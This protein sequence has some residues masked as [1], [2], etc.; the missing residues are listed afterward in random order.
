[1]KPAPD[2]IA[3]EVLARERQVWVALATGDAVADLAL[4]DEDFLGLYPD[5]PSGRSD[6]A[7]QLAAGPVAADWQLSDIRVL[8]LSSADPGLVLVAYRARF[9]RLRDGAPQDWWISSIWRATGPG[10]WRN[11]FSQDTPVSATSEPS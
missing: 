10:V 9:R 7:A 8:Q 5:G 4:L 11:V 1:M 6:H 2:A 3:A